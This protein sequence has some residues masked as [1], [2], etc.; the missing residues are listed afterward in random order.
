MVEVELLYRQHLT[1]A[2]RRLLIDVAGEGVGLDSTLGRHEVEI[3][4]FGSADDVATP[5]PVSPFLM[6]ATAVHRTARTLETAS[7]VEDRHPEAWCPA[8]LDEAGGF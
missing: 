4:V 2:D 7:F 1:D 8:F 5:A 3:A 6:F